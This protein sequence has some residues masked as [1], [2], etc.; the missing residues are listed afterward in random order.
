MQLAHPAVAAGVA[1]HSDF[2]RD[3]FARLRRT[4]A[5][6]HAVVFGS[7]LRAERALDRINAVH[8]LVNGEVPESGVRYDALDPSLLLWVHATLVDTAIRVYDRLIAPLTSAEAEAYHREA[9]QVAVRLGVPEAAVPVTL[10]DLRAEMA[11]MV[12]SGEVSVS[13]TAR[14]LAQSV[15]YP[16]RTL[17][18]VAWDAAHLVSMSVMPAPIRRGYGIGWSGARERGVE[19]LASAG[20]R[21]VPL[22][23]AALRFVPAARAAERRLRVAGA[24]MPGT[25]PDR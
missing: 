22:L 17:P 8:G 11:R 6:T 14:G 23:P 5:A 18:R 10:V 1:E 2:R 12:A 19:R 15:L 20:R 4:L 7:T 9:R 3:P 24:I 16:S 25:H 21:I 13:A